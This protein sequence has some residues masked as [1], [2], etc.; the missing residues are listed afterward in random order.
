M[1][2]WSSCWRPCTSML[3]TCPPS[4]H[5]RTTRRGRG[6]GRGV[7]GREPAWGRE[8]ARRF[9][10]GRSWNLYGQGVGGFSL[11]AAGFAPEQLHPQR[12]WFWPDRLKRSRRHGCGLTS[13]AALVCS[14]GTS[15]GSRAP[16]PGPGRRWARTWPLRTWRRRGWSSSGCR[17]CPGGGP[18]RREGGGG[19]TRGRGFPVRD[20]PWTLTPPR[21]S[22]GRRGCVRGW[23]RRQVESSPARLPACGACLPAGR[24]RPAG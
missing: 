3:P 11:C 19:H 5:T 16:S 22:G 9:G 23:H 24:H 10:L 20:R 6:A 15:C 2:R 17:P 13:T 14:N 7:C 21:V 8:R 1:R 12:H 18:Q 4:W